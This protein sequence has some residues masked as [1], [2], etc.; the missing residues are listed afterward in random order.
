MSAYAVMEQQKT[1][2]ISAQDKWTKADQFGREKMLDVISES[3]SRAS[4]SWK[5]LPYI[6]KLNL[7]NRKWTA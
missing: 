3:R 4:L 5:K 6:V 1:V 7:S 2:V